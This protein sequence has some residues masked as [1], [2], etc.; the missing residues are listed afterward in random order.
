MKCAGHA[1]DSCRVCTFATLRRAGG[2]Y[3]EEGGGSLALG[4]LCARILRLILHWVSAAPSFLL[5]KWGRRGGISL[6]AAAAAGIWREISP[7]GSAWN[8]CTCSGPCFHPPCRA[9]WGARQPPQKLR[10]A[11]TNLLRMRQ[12][13]PARETLVRKQQQINNS[14]FFPPLACTE[15]AGSDIFWPER[16]LF[17]GGWSRKLGVARGC[18]CGSVCFCLFCLAVCGELCAQNVPLALGRA[19]HGSGAEECPEKAPAVTTGGG[20]PGGKR[21]ARGGCVCRTRAARRTGEGNMRLHP[22]LG[23][24]CA[25]AAHMCC[26]SS[27]DVRSDATNF[28]RENCTQS[29]RGRPQTPSR[30]GHLRTHCSPGGGKWYTEGGK[31]G[32]KCA[33]IVW[34]SV[35]PLRPISRSVWLTPTLC[36]SRQRGVRDSE[37]LVCKED[38]EAKEACGD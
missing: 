35:S 33:Q 19:R 4:R 18:L 20:R 3:G 23:R 14:A 15:R 5:T 31:L 8:P 2:H 9:P 17:S 24:K 27:C 1:G 32:A 13:V 12:S 10:G 16:R 6:A 30:K 25:Q 34:A 21:A 7:R 22:L 38:K 36:R 26:F 28:D 11:C 37:E 29:A